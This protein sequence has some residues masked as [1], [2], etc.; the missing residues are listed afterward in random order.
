M[1]DTS[2]DTLNHIT[3]IQHINQ[4]RF[5]CISK[6]VV[7]M[8]SCRH[9]NCSFQYI[10]KTTQTLRAR[11]NGHRSSLRT[12]KGCTHVIRHFTREHKPSDLIIKPLIKVLPKHLGEYEMKYI[13][14]FG[15]L[16]PYGGNERLD[17]PYIDA[18]AH[19]DEGKCIWRLFDHAK[20][21]RA[22]LEEE[23]G[24]ILLSLL[25]FIVQLQRL[26]SKLFYLII[27]VI[28]LFMW[29]NALLIVVERTVLC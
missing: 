15:T 3:N 12:K 27:M 8:I 22:T 23:E 16:Y 2:N 19:Y 14:S 28:I 25:M 9:A 26:L 6:D 29:L 10:G 17:K 13:K 5:S 24:L 21:N 7:Y 11:A 18:Q 20:S 4:E 1:L